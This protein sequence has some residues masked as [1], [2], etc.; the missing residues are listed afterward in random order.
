MY[1]D[2]GKG[3]RVFM[4]RTLEIAMDTSHADENYEDRVL[5]IASQPLERTK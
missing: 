2:Y 1:E 5:Q 4:L 3:Q